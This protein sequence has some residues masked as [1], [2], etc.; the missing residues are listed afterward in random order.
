VEQEKNYQEE[1][2]RQIQRKEVYT[3]LSTIKKKDHEAQEHRIQFNEMNEYFVKLK[4]REQGHQNQINEMFK[5]LSTM[6]A[7]STTSSKTKNQGG[8]GDQK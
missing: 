2:E 1:Q 7:S 6:S 4:E 3:I 8:V 5:I